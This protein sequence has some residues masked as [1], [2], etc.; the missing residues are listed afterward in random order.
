MSEELLGIS[1][2]DAVA[3]LRSER[4]IDWTGG[5]VSVR[6]NSS[7]FLT[8]PGGSARRFWRLD[9]SDML[10][11]SLGCVRHDSVPRPPIGVSLHAYLYMKLR[12][13][14][15]IVHTHAGASF[16]VSCIAFGGLPSLPP[17]GP[18]G[19][20]PMIG[21]AGLPSHT[22][23]TQHAW[24]EQVTIPEIERLADGWDVALQDQGVAFLDYEHGVYVLG[25]SLEGALIDLARVE[26]S[27]ALW[28]QTVRNRESIRVHRPHPK[29]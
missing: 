27:A 12:N 24:I 9:P 20:V 13:L 2:C 14:R 25:G 18:L 6:L 8:T 29:D 4:L 16:I 15:A 19:V 23:E 26:A 3:A 21:L 5:A 7:A 10:R 1:L 28:L 11:L 22:I 17:T